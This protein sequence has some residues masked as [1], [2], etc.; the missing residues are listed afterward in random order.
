MREPKLDRSSLDFTESH[1]SC[2][3][4]ERTMTVVRVLLIFL[5]VNRELRQ[6]LVR[7]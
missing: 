6:E 4:R 7:A 5:E 2:E 1:R 3:A